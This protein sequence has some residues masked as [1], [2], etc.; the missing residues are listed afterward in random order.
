MWWLEADLVRPLAD[1]V[2]DDPA[3][4][5][6]QHDLPQSAID[7]QVVRKREDELDERVV[8]ERETHLA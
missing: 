8:E 1:L 6:P 7:L 3:H 4:G 2:G 5:L